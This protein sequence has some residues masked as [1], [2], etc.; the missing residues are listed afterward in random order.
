VLFY[1]IA[2]TVKADRF[3]RHPYITIIIP[4]YNRAASL[5][6]IL[7][8]LDSV[9]TSE[10]QIEAVIVNNGSTDET[11]RL[12]LSEKKRFR[13]FAFEV[14]DEAR[15]GKASAVNR[16][17]EFSHGNIIVIFDDDIVIHPQ[18]LVKHAE[19]HLTTGFD[20]VQGRVL[21]GFDPEGKA[22]DANRLLEYNIPIIDYGE[23]ERIISGLIGTNMSFKREVFEK[24]GFFDTR[25]GP[26]AAGFSED[27]EYSLRIRE[28]GFTIGYT[29]HALVYHELNPARYGRS[30]NRAVE[31]RKGM[32]R[33]LYRRDSLFLHILPNL[34]ANC[35]RY[36]IYKALG[37]SQKAYKTE[38]RIMKSLGYLVGQFKR[39]GAGH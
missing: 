21:P 14:L 20:A 34:F 6:R 16:G 39:V 38:G 9:E 10:F 15:R 3:V 7:Q 37:K 11:N 33:S 36:M 13:P 31:Y 24:V 12:L 28:A 25:L 30:Y 32:S 19:C 35:V 29:P 22:A 5:R 27:T 17:L 8:S 2:I 1:T 23:N 18:C 4:T 26:G